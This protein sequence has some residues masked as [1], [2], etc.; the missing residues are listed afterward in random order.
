MGK[1]EVVEEGIP[2]IFILFII[3]FIAHLFDIVKGT[4][5]EP[6]HHYRGIE[7]RHD[8]IGDH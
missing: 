8:N 6:S 3:W 7:L 5:I 1:Q 2:L 4:G